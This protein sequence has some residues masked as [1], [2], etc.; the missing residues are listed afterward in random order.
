MQG[1]LDLR[2][3]SQPVLLDDG[4]VAHE[5]LGRLHNLVVD[6]PPSRRF[7]REE[8]RRW[9]DVE[10][11][12]TLGRRQKSVAARRAQADARTHRVLP[13]APIRALAL[14]PSSG[15]LEVA[16]HC[17]RQRT[18]AISNQVMSAAARTLSSS[19]LTQT[20]P[21]SLVVALTTLDPYRLLAEPQKILLELLADRY[22]AREG[23]KVE[24]MG[25]APLGR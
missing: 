17:E 25:R 2:K 6:D 14:D 22:C 11:L 7:P 21:Q 20:S 13:H 4:Q 5:P 12:K 10:D 8:H 24:T 18:P 9:M 15:I 19:V 16:S 3:L 1:I 23:L